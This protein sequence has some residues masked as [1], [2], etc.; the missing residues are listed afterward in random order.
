VG[1]CIVDD[2]FVTTSYSSDHGVTW[3][4]G[5][6]LTTN[7]YYG[8]ASNGSIYVAVRYGSAVAETSTTGAT[9]TWTA[10]TLPSN[11]NWYKVVWDGSQFIAIANA[12]TAAATSPDGIT[13]T[14]ATLTSA[15]DWQGLAANTLGVVAVATGTVATSSCPA[16]VVTPPGPFWTNFVRT[17][18]VP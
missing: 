1:F 17:H 9:G 15:D 8:I 13:W 5:A 16:I 14:A 11:S 6:T 18:E 10:R 7:G 3:T 12:Q 2:S 4:D